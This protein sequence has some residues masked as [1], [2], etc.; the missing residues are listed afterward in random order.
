MDGLTPVGSDSDVFIPLDVPGMF[1]EQAGRSDYEHYHHTQHDH[2]GAE[3][4]EYQRHSALVAAIGAYQIANLPELVTRQNLRAPSAR[5]MGVQLDGTKVTQ[6]T[7]GGAAAAAGMLV[8]DVILSIDGTETKSQNNISR[9]VREGGSKKVVKLKRGEAELELT[10]DW[11]NDP[12]EPRRLLQL[13]ERAAREAVR[14][15]EREAEEAVKAQKRAAEQAVREAQQKV[16]E[17][18]Q[19]EMRATDEAVKQALEPRLEETAAA[20]GPKG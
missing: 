2:L 11:S 8:G 6:V 9:A 16:E 13:E 3:I 5:R 15:M 20:A 10:L 12:D 17:A 14:K 7:E 4:P 18:V 1:W 19:A